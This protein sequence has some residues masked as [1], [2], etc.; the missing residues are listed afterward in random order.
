MGT[1]SRRGVSPACRRGLKEDLPQGEEAIRYAPDL[2]PVEQIWN[3][4]KYTEL[5]N[6]I[7]HDIDD[8]HGAVAIALA[9]QAPEQDLLPGYFKHAGL[10]L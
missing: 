6:Y 1:S 10:F 9:I 3:R 8:L 7:A 4:S 5:A 2:N